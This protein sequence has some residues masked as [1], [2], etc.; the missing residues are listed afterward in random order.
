MP[1]GTDVTSLTNTPITIKCSVSGLPK[2]RIKWM[3]DGQMIGLVDGYKISADGSL[4][5]ESAKPE[6]S[7]R[8]TC[9]AENVKGQD[10]ESSTIKVIGELHV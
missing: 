7:G 10:K 8:Y 4:S 3:K 2:P 5:I 6:D 9:E 1:V